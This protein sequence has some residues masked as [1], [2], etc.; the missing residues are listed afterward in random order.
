MD[1][2]EKEWDEAKQFGQYLLEQG[3]DESEAVVEFRRQD[4][5]RTL[6]CSAFATKEAMTCRLTQLRARRRLRGAGCGM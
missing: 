3:E 4:L 6:G 5:P 2:T 1:L